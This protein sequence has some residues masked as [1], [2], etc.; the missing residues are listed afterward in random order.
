MDGLERL[1]DIWIGRRAVPAPDALAA[2]AHLRPATVITGAS[3]GLGLALAR[4]IA[5]EGR[6]VMLVARSIDT[7][8][9]AADE[10]RNAYPRALVI[11]EVLD[12]GRMDA[13]EQLEQ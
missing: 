12:V 8:V 11:E 2:V 13:F 7:L 1:A 10:L 3:E 4:R 6:A 9:A 5:K